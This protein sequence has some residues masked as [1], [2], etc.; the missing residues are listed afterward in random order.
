[1]L[2]IMDHILQRVIQEF[3]LTHQAGPYHRLACN[4]APLHNSATFSQT[5]VVLRFYQPYQLATC[6]RRVASTRFRIGAFHGKN[7]SCSPPEASRIPSIKVSRKLGMLVAMT[8]G[9]DSSG[10]RASK[11]SP[12]HH[13][14]GRNRKIK[15]RMAANLAGCPKAFLRRINPHG[16]CFTSVPAWACLTTWAPDMLPSRQ[17]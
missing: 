2:C 11:I 8:P 1:M 10:P 9:K 16:K 13:T 17:T 3:S 4:L 12:N 5:S 14:L 7:Q 6:S 15:K